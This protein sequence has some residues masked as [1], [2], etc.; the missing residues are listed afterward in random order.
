MLPKLR[1]VFDRKKVATPK[2]KGLVQIEL[3]YEKKRKWI[4]TGVKV[5]SDQWDERRWV[6]NSL[7]SVKLN[8]Q[9]FDQKEELETWLNSEFKEH[10]FDF[11]KLDLW[12]ERK[13]VLPKDESFIDF[14]ERRIRERRDISE[15]TRRM[16][17]RLISSLRDFGRIVYFSDLTKANIIR[18]HEWLKGKYTNDYSIY[19]YIKY[20]RTYTNEALKLELIDKY[21][22]TGLHFK[23]GEPRSDKFLTEDEVNKI[24]DCEISTESLRN[25]RDLFLVQCYTGLS[26]SD[27]MLVDFKKAV[28]RGKFYVLTGEREKTKQSYY[29][30]LLQPVMEILKRHDFRLP[31]MSNQQYNM[32]LKVLADA[33][34]LKEPI[35][36]H[37]GRRT[38]GYMLLNNGMSIE[39]VAKV[40]GHANIKTTQAVYAKILDTTMDKAFFELEKKMKKKSGGK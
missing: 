9:L 21:P 5:Y 6:I 29:V 8:R 17:K 15:H 16:Q 35:T 27:L 37:Y 11:D 33:A 20:T 28:K 39:Q 30:V 19:D 14:C 10:A 40:L 24:A 7:D 2:K 18:Y 36:S 34:K 31:K 23:R 32:R 3:L 26:F 4:T 38:A 12:L 1:M 25:V 13:K 22:F